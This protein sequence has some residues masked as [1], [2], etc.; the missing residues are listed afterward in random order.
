MSGTTQAG[1]GG[2]VVALSASA[3]PTNAALSSDCHAPV[4]R[5]G[6]QVTESPDTET[7]TDNVPFPLTPWRGSALAGAAVTAA[8]AN[9]EEMTAKRTRSIYAPTTTTYGCRG[10]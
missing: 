5:H 6:P 7:V 9:V 4:H 1:T 10:L 3:R 8:N 2:A